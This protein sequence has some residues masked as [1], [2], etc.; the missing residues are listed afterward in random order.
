VKNTKCR[1][2]YVKPTC[3]ERTPR[4]AKNCKCSSSQGGR[5]LSVPADSVGNDFRGFLAQN[6]KGPRIPVLIKCALR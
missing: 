6:L 1:E 2:T 4:I 3:K 5:K